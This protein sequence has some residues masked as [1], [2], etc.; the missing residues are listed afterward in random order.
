[1]AA[2]GE[3]KVSLHLKA[4]ESGQGFVIIIVWGARYKYYLLGIIKVDNGGL[5]SV[6]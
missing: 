6:D 3:A 2:V 1:M 4:W 5:G